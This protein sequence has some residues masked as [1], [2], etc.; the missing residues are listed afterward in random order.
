MSKHIGNDSFRLPE[1]LCIYSCFKLKILLR[2]PLS[3]PLCI[4]DYTQRLR[5]PC[6]IFILNDYIFRQPDFL[7]IEE[8]QQS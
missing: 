8:N 4:L 1:R 6:L 3:A 2:C 7:S 5:S